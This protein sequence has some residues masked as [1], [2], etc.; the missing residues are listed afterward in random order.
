[1]KAILEFDLDS[2]EDRVSH[3]QAVKAS[4]MANAIFE[5]GLNLRKKAMW[6]AE[7]LEK[8]NVVDAI[9]EMI[10]EVLKDHGL[11]PEKLV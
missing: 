8:E 6:K 4:D 10:D 9:F 3:L 1:M 11:D 2:S 7:S 5:I